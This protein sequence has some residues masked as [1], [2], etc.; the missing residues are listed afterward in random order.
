[1]TKAWAKEIVEREKDSDMTAYFDGSLKITDMKDMFRY[2]FGFGQ[3]E[4][5]VILASLVMCGAKFKAE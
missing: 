2:R 3:H 5:D 4:T 1:M